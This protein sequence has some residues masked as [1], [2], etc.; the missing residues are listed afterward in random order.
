MATRAYCVLPVHRL[1]NTGGTHVLTCKVRLILN[2]AAIHTVNTTE[3]LVK[4]K[5][6]QLLQWYEEFTGL[7]EVRMAQNRVL[8]AEAKFVTAQERR[9]E[10]STLVSAIQSKLKDLWAELDN[11]SR[12]EERY[13]HLI[14]QEHSILKEEKR[15]AQE[16]QSCER[17]ERECFA[18]LSSAVKESHEKE[19]AQAE[20]TKYW[21]I[22]GSVIGTIIGIIG[23]SVNNQIKMK[24]MRRLI[25]ESL[26]KHGEQDILTDVSQA[27][28]KHEKSLSV[29]VRE[30]QHIA[31]VPS[32]K[33]SGHHN[34]LVKKF[35]SH[36]NNKTVTLSEMIDEILKLLKKQEVCFDKNFQELKSVIVSQNIQIG[37][38]QVVV[39]PYDTHERLQQQLRN[40]VTFFAIAAVVVPLVCKY[41]GLL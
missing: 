24:E 1:S 14:T 26:L 7:D 11:T 27:L 36:V 21:S 31:S 6:G 41:F 30:M 13:V 35:D 40:T 29:I 22:I 23:S 16:F 19:R 10:A 15:A 12:G 34:E 9:R 17:E 5:L 4:K 18:V 2:P 8:E 39:L 25:G 20:R 38:D 32:D 37:D 3:S 33:V 28:S